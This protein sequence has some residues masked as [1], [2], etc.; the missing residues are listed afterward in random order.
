MSKDDFS[1]IIDLEEKL[2]YKK[3]SQ[4]ALANLVDEDF[5]ELGSLNHVY[6]KQDFIK[7][8]TVPTEAMRTAK[9]FKARYLTPDVIQLT[10]ISFMREGVHTPVLSDYRSSIWRQMNGQWKLCFHQGTPCR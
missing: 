5:S 2:L 4:H 6:T 8:L 9:N 10:Y 1:F 3:E 7:D